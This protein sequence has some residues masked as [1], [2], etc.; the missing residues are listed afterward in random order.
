MMMMMTVMMAMMMTKKTTHYTRLT[1]VTMQIT[2]NNY[3][4]FSFTFFFVLQCKCS[5]A[6][7]FAYSTHTLFFVF[8]LLACTSFTQSAF[9]PAYL[10]LFTLLSSFYSSTSPCLEYFHH[11]HSHTY[12]QLLFFSKMR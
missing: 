11:T 10:P 2:I 9:W 6:R 12:T 5:R 7:Y 3:Y 1:F 8:L 4:Y